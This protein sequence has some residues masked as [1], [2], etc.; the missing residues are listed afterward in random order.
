MTTTKLCIAIALMAAITF[1]TRLFPF[2]VFGRGEKPAPIIMYLGKYLPPALITAIV[3]YCF[4]DISFFSGA[5]GI[6]EILSAAVVIAL[7][8]KFR[9]TMLSIAAGTIL[10][11]VL[12]RI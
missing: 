5:H 7:H 10:Y 3:V 11:M 9:N 6:P 4:K 12:L 2:V 1:C 8:Y